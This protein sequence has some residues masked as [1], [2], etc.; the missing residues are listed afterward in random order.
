MIDATE[1]ER[2]STNL[3]TSAYNI[4]FDGVP[5]FHVLTVILSISR[6]WNNQRPSVILTDHTGTNIAGRFSSPRKS[7]LTFKQFAGKIVQFARVRIDGIDKIIVASETPDAN[8]TSERT[9]P[10]SSLPSK[11][12]C[13]LNNVAMW[14]SERE[15][16]NEKERKVRKRRRSEGDIGEADNMSSNIDRRGY[17]VNLSERAKGRCPMSRYTLAARVRARLA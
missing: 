3:S 10:C 14:V 11:A 8:E 16:E 9:L 7:P 4:S 2:D 15:K 6:H 12:Y 17:T 5:T 1:E 13:R